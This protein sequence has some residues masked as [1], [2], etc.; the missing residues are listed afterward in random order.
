ME[1]RLVCRRASEMT[2]IFM[3]EE[4][5]MKA[6]LDTL[7]PRLFPRIDFRCVPHQGKTDL[8]KSLPRKLKAWQ[9]PGDKFVVIRDS[10]GADCRK[11]KRRLLDI[12]QAAGRPDVLIRIACHE[13][14]AWYFG[15]PG[16]MAEAFEDESLKHL[17]TRAKYRDPDRI[18]RPSGELT[19][20]CNTFQKVD[21]ARRM[22]EYLS[23]ETNTSSSFVALI[24]GVAR[25][26]AGT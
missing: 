11:V 1:T 12:C 7:L 26:N 17:G 10:D 23:R 16:A 3:V 9:F 22:G 20:L 18:P 5:S 8:E 4:P 13:M 21:G 2:I 19:R 25:A 15:D 14:E 24:D 6:L